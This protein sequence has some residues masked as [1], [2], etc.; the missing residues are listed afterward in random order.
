[1]KMGGLGMKEEGKG[2]DGVG[3]F[4]RTIVVGVEMDALSKELLTWALVKVAEQGDRVVAIHV[5]RRRELHD[6][7]GQFSLLSHLKAFESV[8]SVYEDFCNLKQ[9]D[10]KLKICRGSSARRVL[11][12]QAKSISANIIV[13]GISRKSCTIGFSASVAKYCARKLPLECWVLA[14]NN[15]KVEYQRESKAAYA[16]SASIDGADL[17][18]LPN[19]YL[20]LLHRSR[21]KNSKVCHGGTS[22]QP[23][24]KE[25][26]T[27]KNEGH[28]NYQDL[29]S[30]SDRCVIGIDNSLPRS[31]SIRSCSICA[32]DSVS[33]EEACCS[34]GL[35][36][37]ALHSACSTEDA[38]DDFSAIALIE[39][40][41]SEAASSSNSSLMLE[42]PKV[43]PGW[44]LLHRA[45]THS[46]QAT[47]VREVSVVEWA[48]QLPT[49]HSMAEVGPD[50]KPLN[51]ELTTKTPATSSLQDGANLNG[52][53][54]AI[55][56]IGNATS[57][58]LQSAEPNNTVNQL[59]HLHNKYSSTCR[60]F[61]YQ[62]LQSATS[63][64][65]L[66]N[67]IGKGGNSRVYKGH[68]PD[69]KELAVKILKSSEDAVKEFCLE[70]DI[71]SSLHHSNIISLLGFCFE[72][73][74]L[75]LVH[76]FVLKGSLEENL[77]GR[78]D[79][80]VL[81]WGRRYNV[82]I[83]VAAAL[84]YLH[85]GTQPVIHRDVK[86]SNILLDD[87][88]E[89]KL[90]DFGLA[91]WASMSSAQIACS[92]VAGTFGY[93]APEYFMYGKV[94]EKIDVY[95]FGVVLLELLSG[96]KPINNEYPKGQE[97]LIM[98]AKPLL[99]SG[100]LM[101]LLDPNLGDNY[102][103]HQLEK[104]VLAASVCVRRAPRFRPRM[105]LIFKLL[106][107]DDAIMKW[108]RLQAIASEDFDLLYDEV[109][110]ASDI[111]S[112]LNLALLDVE[113]DSL[114]V[115]SIEQG[116]N[117]LTVDKS[118]DVYLQER[119]SRSSSFD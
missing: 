85:S 86:S 49:R 83:R 66:E 91:I 58:P 17:C 8:L 105:S 73:N 22:K 43:R 97:S 106:Q 26:R 81:T 57:P 78:K 65:S 23:L 33:Q 103:N 116:V 117:Y 104:L 67:L 61:G 55:V 110:P 70:I 39:T 51:A 113:D 47:M 82:A 42:L 31:T 4:G 79:D 115:S 7:D 25:E 41:D 89:P 21:S 87:D 62:E 12:Q 74:K 98:W 80:T 71:I 111:Q 14:V 10:L 56:G 68:L 118:L 64:F 59:E 16:L 101:Q 48:M 35:R 92:D 75:I 18:P 84:N 63:N 19:G 54:G 93:L 45:I 30:Q 29:G 6:E 76:D 9:I 52:D 32:P 77:H 94:S 13:V 11:V 60:L 1:M 96:R 38:S 46:W 40:S 24:L 95:A 3:G 28:Q 53:S 2:R 108:A 50:H 109:S 34:E 69:G 72:E 44:P 15:G 37:C 100:K 102:D 20:G 107:G 5:L 114:S 27:G 36:P 88:F 90:S 99:Q 119:W 112:H